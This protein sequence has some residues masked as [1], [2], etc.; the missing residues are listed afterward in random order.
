MRWLQVRRAEEEHFR[1]CT[2]E[3]LVEQLLTRY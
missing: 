2:P 3:E 1:D